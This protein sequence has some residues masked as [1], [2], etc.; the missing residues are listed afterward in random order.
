MAV[1]TPIRGASRTSRRSVEKSIFLC[2][3][4]SPARALNALS[5]TRPR[6]PRIPI[7]EK[8]LLLEQDSPRRNQRRHR[9]RSVAIQGP[10]P[11][12]FDRLDR[13]VAALLAITAHLCRKVLLIEPNRK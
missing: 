9:E 1:W 10:P 12:P 7:F 13:R 6:I 5:R 3:S 8:D 2:W 11:A 4:G